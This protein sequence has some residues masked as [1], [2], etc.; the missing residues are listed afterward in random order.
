MDWNPEKRF[1]NGK[2]KESLNLKNVDN[3][4]RASLCHVVIKPTYL[5]RKEN[6]A[7]KAKNATKNKRIAHL[8]GLV[9][10]WSIKRNFENGNKNTPTGGISAVVPN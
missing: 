1:I 7:Q 2:G 6:L 3:A 9:K 4:I 10:L 5:G 8:N